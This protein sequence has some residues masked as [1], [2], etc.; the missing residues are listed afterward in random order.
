MKTS[1][2]TLYFFLCWMALVHAQ[3]GDDLCVFKT[4]E[5]WHPQFSVEGHYYVLAD[6]NGDGASDLLGFSRGSTGK[7]YVSLSQG[8]HFGP[9]ELWYEGFCYNNSLPMA[10]DFDGD[11]KTDI[12]CFSP[13]ASNVVQI[14]FSAGNRFSPGSLEWSN[15]KPIAASFP[16]VADFNGDGKAD[17]GRVSPGVEGEIFV[18]LS[19]GY[20]FTE[21]ETPWAMGYFPNPNQVKVGDVNGDGKADVVAFIQGTRARVRAFLSNGQQFLVQPELW[22]QGFSFD[23]EVP[24]I[25]QFSLDGVADAITIIPPDGFILGAASTQHSFGNKVANMGQAFFFEQYKPI[26]GDVNGDQLDDL[27]ICGRYGTVIVMPARLDVDQLSFIR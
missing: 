4:T 5:R 19:N 16:L 2:F 21:D 3:F 18:A 15:F 8:D 7:V 14:L 22:K 20:R 10:G 11:G 24:V 6:L 17:I 12:A 9:V 26:I 27:V 23:G 13:T 1:I 25:G